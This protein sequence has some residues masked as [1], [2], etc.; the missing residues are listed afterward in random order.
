MSAQR[1]SATC[2]SIWGAC[3]GNVVT[4]GSAVQVLSMYQELRNRLAPAR[5]VSSAGEEHDDWDIPTIKNLVHD[6]S[7]ASN[8]VV[9]PC[10]GL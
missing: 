1:G 7:S 8:I 3:R 4:L 5:A 9:N 2:L 6:A 10:E